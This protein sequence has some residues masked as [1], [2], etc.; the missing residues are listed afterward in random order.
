MTANQINYQRHL[1]DQRSHMKNEELTRDR[2]AESKRANLAR[3]IE[4]N[5][6][7][8][9]RE[10]ETYRNNIATE[11]ETRRSNLA[12]E[13]ETNRAN[14][15]R[16]QETS[17][18]NLESERL[19]E[20]GID[21]GSEDSRYASDTGYRGRVDSAYVNKWGVNPT[22]VVNTGKAVVGAVTSPQVADTLVKLD[23]KGFFNNPIKTGLAGAAALA[24]RKAREEK[25]KDDKSKKERKPNSRRF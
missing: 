15:A 24:K 5:R 2:D 6:A 13:I 20:K 19:K 11:G 14:L 4:T 16:E 1:E 17:R 9:A 18:S 3:E 10:A 21:V 25:K 22:D 8:L 7:N 23:N 12:R